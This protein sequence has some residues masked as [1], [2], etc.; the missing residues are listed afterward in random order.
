MIKKVSICFLFVF[1]RALTLPQDFPLLYKWMHE[2]YVIPQWQLN[3]PKLE[4]AVYFEKML[5][6][7]HQRLYII[8]IEGQD[9]GYLEIY[10][11]K[12]DRLSLYYSALEHDLGWHV[13]L[14]EKNVVG[15]GHFKAVMRMM[16]YFVFEYSR[17][18]KIVGEPDENVKSY[19][20][21]AQEIAF[22]AQQKIQMLEK[23]AIL[24]HCFREKF[25]E[26]CGEFIPP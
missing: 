4:L 14:G 21:V 26:K 16:C 5:I 20:Y 18:E 24:Y 13:L 9:V 15:K 17:A 23:T 22:E 12:R 25:Y 2:P 8:Q 3:K 6:D 1:L 7:D 10:E 19:E 11:A